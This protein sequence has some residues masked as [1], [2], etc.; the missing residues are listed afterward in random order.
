MARYM[1]TVTINGRAIS[2][3]PGPLVVLDGVQIV[4][5]RN[6]LFDPNEPG[7]ATVEILDYDGHFVS[8]PALYQ[9]PIVITTSVGTLYRGFVDGID[10]STVTVT[11]DDGDQV[12]VWR[13]EFTSSDVL[14]ILARTTPPGIPASSSRAPV[15]RAL[16]SDYWN[17][18]TGVFDGS[19]RLLDIRTRVAE[20]SDV[21]IGGATFVLPPGRLGMTMPDVA[22]GDDL[23]LMIQRW[24]A[25]RVQEPVAAKYRPTD[26]TVAPHRFSAQG[27]LILAYVSSQIVV[28]ATGGRLVRGDE[29]IIDDN[30]AVTSTISN[31]VAAITGQDFNDPMTSEMWQNP[32]NPSATIAYLT[33]YSGQDMLF[34][35]P[36]LAA[37][38][39]RTTYDTKAQFYIA[40]NTS[41]GTAGYK[42]MSDLAAA[43]NP[44]VQAVN[45]K[46]YAPPLTFDTER[47]NYG[48]AIESALFAG[49]DLETPWTF[50]GAIFEPLTGWGPF[51][52]MIGAVMTYR[53]GWQI[54][55]KFAP[56]AGAPGNLAIN[57]LVTSPT[58]TFNQYAE[59]ITL[60]TLGTVSGGI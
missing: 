47:W 2:A 48:S 46:F 29:L 42:H 32:S 20:V 10:I 38:S 39:G 49:Y 8:D 21:T 60:A 19:Q 3:S 54:E 37:N 18:S 7:T 22:A 5:G 28:Q 50:P 9:A 53:D 17:K 1:P 31:N 27:A 56:A 55:G 41:T 51:F 45:G 24:Y 59:Y 35:V 12:L 52:Q 23:Y 33:S 14:A 34:V 30:A 58:P 13:A 26:H 36:G 57:Q 43:I 44:F 16:G 11:D 4:W 40:P 6:G 15:E 25:S